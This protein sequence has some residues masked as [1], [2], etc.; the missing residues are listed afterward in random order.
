MSF[1]FAA[2]WPALLLLVFLTSAPTLAADEMAARVQQL[3]KPYIEGGGLVGMTV[4]VVHDDETLILGLG[5]VARDVEQTP[6]GNTMY[7]IGSVSKV[8][9]GILLADAVQQGRAALDQPAGELLPAGVKMPA[10]GE[11]PILLCH[12]ATHSSGLPRLPSNLA[13]KDAT[14]P[15]ADYTVDNLYDFLDGHRLRREPGE[16]VEYSNLGVGLLGHL[17][18]LDAEQSYE[19]LMQERIAEPLGMTDTCIALSDEQ[20][21]RLAKPYNVDGD[22][23]A[24]WDLP[25]L[26][27]AG[28]LR[29][30]MSDMLKFASAALSP[31]PGELGKAIELSWQQHQDPLAE[32]DFAMGLAWH[33]ARDGTTRWHSGQTGGYHS[34]IY[35][36][37]QI[38]AAVVILS[39]TATGEI[40]VLGEQ[41]VRMLA[42]AEVEPRNFDEPLK[43][44]QAMLDRY[45]GKYQLVPGFVLEVTTT[46]GKLYVQAT[47]Q[48]KARVHPRSDTEWFYKIVDAKLVFEVDDQGKCTS[49][50][51]HQNGMKLPA[52]RLDE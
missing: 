44:D 29:S 1:V 16:K 52:K 39:N 19:E 30:S 26:A 35:V 2:R 31:P 6:D 24:N 51:L 5:R 40:D 11:H 22:A 47:G 43:V 12:L 20:R 48:G 50:T 3:A 33:I 21:A 42:G 15:Y 27:G 36:N 13:P 49:L 17:L 37:R 9:T 38:N 28:A 7:E 45:V 4:G 34:V 23:E 32:G 14:N 10:R 46:D 41:I 25:T 18:A 8:F